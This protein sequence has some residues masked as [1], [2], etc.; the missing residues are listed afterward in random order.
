MVILQQSPEPFPTLNRTV[1]P[2]VWAP[3]GHQEH[4]ALPLVGTFSVVVLYIFVERT[5]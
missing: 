1:T 3:R 2:V 4:I 5:A